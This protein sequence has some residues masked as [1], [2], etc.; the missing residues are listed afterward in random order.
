MP[1]SHSPQRLPGGFD[2]Q[3]PKLPP[4]EQWRRPAWL[5]GWR[6]FAA[7][8]PA[9]LALGLLGAQGVN[10]EMLHQGGKPYGQFLGGNAEVEQW[11]EVASYPEDPAPF[12]YAARP[13]ETAY[14]GAEIAADAEQESRDVT[15]NYGSASTEPAAPPVEVVPIVVPQDTPAAQTA[16]PAT[17][18]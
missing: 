18:G 8:I 5:R 15:V 2:F 10:P 17:P 3:L 4:F 16:V 13:D 6:L 9:G 7:T 12:G 14:A 11:Q 1:V